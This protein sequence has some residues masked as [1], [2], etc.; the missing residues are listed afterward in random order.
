MAKRL[1]FSK[2]TLMIGAVILVVIVVLIYGMREGFQNSAASSP[3]SSYLPPGCM[4]PTPGSFSTQSTCSPGYGL[5]MSPSNSN[6]SVCCPYSSGCLPATYFSGFTGAGYTCPSGYPLQSSISNGAKQC[7]PNK[8]GS[9][10][11]SGP[12]SGTGPD[13]KSCYSTSPMMGCK[14]GF[15]SSYSLLSPFTITCCPNTSGTGSGSGS[16]PGSG[17]FG[18]PG[19]GSFGSPGSGSNSPSSVCYTTS[20]LT[21]CKKDYINYYSSLFFNQNVCCAVT[22]PPGCS[23]NTSGV[24]EKNK[25]NKLISNLAFCC[26]K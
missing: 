23:P 7:C 10:S 19:S 2:K 5:G 13:L 26:D 3:F 17:S 12:G 22:V 16:R 24:C 14:V 18:S 4:M 6:I 20:Y 21:P 1:K 11:N 15:N 8:S 9:G 25:T